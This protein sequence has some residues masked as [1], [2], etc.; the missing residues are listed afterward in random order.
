MGIRI[1]DVNRGRGDPR[2]VLAVVMSVEGAFY[3][4]GTENGI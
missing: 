3:K 2:S 4:L 1:S